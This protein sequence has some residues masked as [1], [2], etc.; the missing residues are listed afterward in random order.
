MRDPFLNVP[1]DVITIN[2]AVDKIIGFV[3]EDKT[4]MVFTPNPEIIM[5]A[6]EDS[7]LF[8]ILNDS[9]LNVPDGI[10]IVIASKI[11]KKNIKERV[12]GLDLVTKLF[13]KDLSFYF[14]GSTSEIVEKAKQNLEEKYSG[15]KIL[16]IHNGFFDNNEEE[17]II[18][19]INQKNPDILLVGLGVPKQEKWIYKN[20]NKLNAKVLIGVGGS[21]DVISGKTKRAPEVF[22]NLGLEW[23]YRLIK[24]PKRYKRMLKL[25]AFLL[26]ILTDK[27]N[28]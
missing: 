9:D 11:Q 2:E 24:E 26:R 27:N 15:I 16:G 28:D 22:I 3:G 18:E 23:L 10:G 14:L 5:I 4:H 19:E 8:T 21:L 17:K 20:K 13:E 1:I 25:P 12:G 7:E 6:Q